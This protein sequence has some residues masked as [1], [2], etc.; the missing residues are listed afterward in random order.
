LSNENY[1]SAI[2]AFQEHIERLL[3][4]LF[5][6]HEEL[7][8]IAA[9]DEAMVIRQRHVHHWPTTDA[10][11]NANRPALNRVHAEDCALAG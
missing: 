2:S 6:F 8:G 11:A 9:I 10:L 3:Q 1:A 5:D 7:Y 4:Q